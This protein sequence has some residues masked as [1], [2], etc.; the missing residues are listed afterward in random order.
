IT[1]TLAARVVEGLWGC[2]TAGVVAALALG[3]ATPFFT[4]A[5]AFYGHAPAAACIMGAFAALSLHRGERLSNGRLVLI[6]LLLGCAIVLEYTAAAVA[7]PIALW[8]IWQAPRR[9]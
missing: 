6:G 8:T 4:Y 3:L 5:Q 7:L 2:R 1:C 9:A